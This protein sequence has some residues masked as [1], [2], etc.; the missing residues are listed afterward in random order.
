MNSEDDDLTTDDVLKVAPTIIRVFAAL[1]IFMIL[2]NCFALGI[3]VYAGWQG[4]VWWIVL[5]AGAVVWFIIRVAKTWMRNLMEAAREQ[6]E[7][8]RSVAAQSLVEDVEGTSDDGEG[9]TFVDES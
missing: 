3:L 6:L 4:W 2:L 1:Y 9:S 7:D 8:A 5:P